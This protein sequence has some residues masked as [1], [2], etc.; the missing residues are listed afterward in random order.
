MC[1]ACREVTSRNKDKLTDI[2]GINMCCFR[3]SVVPLDK[4]NKPLRPV[5]LWLD[6]RRAKGLKKL[7][8]LSRT[9]FKMVGMGPTIE[10]NLK[11]SMSR[12][13][14]ENEPE[15]WEKTDKFMM[16]STYIAMQLTGRFADSP[17]AQ[18]GHLPIDFKKGVWYKRAD[19]KIL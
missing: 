18:A 2:L 12:W 4:D 10:L 5:I 9:I 11:R 1:E 16:L 14:Q 19:N 3:D 6:E 8:L 15:I 17:C 13:I 7:P